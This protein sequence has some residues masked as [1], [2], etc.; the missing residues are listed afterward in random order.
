MNY[1][2]VCGR[3]ADHPTKSFHC[4]IENNTYHYCHWHSFIG[5]MVLN[6]HDDFTNPPIES[7][8][9][10]EV[11]DIKYECRPYISD[12]ERWL[13]LY[14]ENEVESIKKE[15]YERGLEDGVNGRI[16]THSICY[17]EGKI[18]TVDA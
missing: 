8:S 7:V 15:A 5:R 6:K 17:E 18:Y 10:E 9:N 13:R 14:D 16:S 2:C 12:G 1:C 4:K 3:E 11:D